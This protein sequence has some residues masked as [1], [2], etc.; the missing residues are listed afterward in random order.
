MPKALV[1]ANPKMTLQ[2]MTTLVL[3]YATCMLAAFCYRSAPNTIIPCLRR[4]GHIKPLWYSLLY[5]Q[6]I[7]PLDIVETSGGPSIEVQTCWDFE[8]QNS[9]GLRF[10]TVLHEARHLS[11]VDRCYYRRVTVFVRR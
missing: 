7:S 5:V 6:Y 10:S 11:K 2:L 4:N 8:F 9:Y 3:S 1:A